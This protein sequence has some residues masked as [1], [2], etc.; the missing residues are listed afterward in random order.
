[1]ANVFGDKLIGAKPV[2]GHVGCAVSLM[3][4]QVATAYHAPMIAAYTAPNEVDAFITGGGPCRYFTRPG[5]V[6]SLDDDI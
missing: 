2:L 3:L 1:M 6:L 4:R 5:G